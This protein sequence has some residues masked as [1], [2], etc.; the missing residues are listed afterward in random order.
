MAY[1]TRK[2]TVVRHRTAAAIALIE[3]LHHNAAEYVVYADVRVGDADD[4]RFD[5]MAGDGL[6]VHTSDLDGMAHVLN[7]VTGATS[8]VAW[9]SLAHAIKPKQVAA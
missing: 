8:L 1:T 4:P 7:L 3:E 2:G 5:A 9:E 6:L